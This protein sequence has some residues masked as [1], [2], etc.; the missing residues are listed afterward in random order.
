[1]T[2]IQ[3]KLTDIARQIRSLDESELEKLIPA[4]ADRV[5]YYKSADEWD[6]AV[7]V[8][9]IA[10]NAQYRLNHF[11]RVSMQCDAILADASRGSCGC[12]ESSVRTSSAGA[13]VK[14]GSARGA[15]P[16]LELVKRK[17]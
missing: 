6:E 13:P 7:V 2:P 10:Q 3:D 14:G 11:P 4:L 8:F 17:G 5:R 16:S 9:A 15:R 12:A 1:M